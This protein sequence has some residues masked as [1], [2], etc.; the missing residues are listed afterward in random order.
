ML[1]V[2]AATNAPNDWTEFPRRF[3]G[4]REP[5]ENI[6]IRMVE[7]AF[8]RNELYFGQRIEIGAQK[9]FQK[10]IQLAHAAATA[11]S[12]CRAID[13]VTDSAPC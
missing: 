10:Q 2:Q 11:P 1:A 5:G 13:H 8:Q 7:Q 3:P 6:L 4:R 12:Y 9:L